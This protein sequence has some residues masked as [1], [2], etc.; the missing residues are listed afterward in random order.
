MEVAY[1]SLIDISKT[2]K[3]NR[4]CHFLTAYSLSG[5]A[6]SSNSLFNKWITLLL[7]MNAMNIATPCKPLMTS[8]AKEKAENCRKAS[9]ICNIQVNPVTVNSRTKMANSFLFF[10]FS[11]TS[12]VFLMEIKVR[13]KKIV[14]AEHKNAT[15]TTKDAKREW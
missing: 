2:A 12:G 4:T 10:V 13:M 11:G 6:L 7:V 15:G 1:T 8:A 3:V 14:F 5:I 9:T